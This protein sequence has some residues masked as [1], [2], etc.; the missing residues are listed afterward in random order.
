M[1]EAAAPLEKVHSR[2]ITEDGVMDDATFE[3]VTKLLNR[4]NMLRLQE[5]MKTVLKIAQN[6]MAFAEKIS[7]SPHCTEFMKH[8]DFIMVAL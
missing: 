4:N 6:G 3:G 8:A 7:R 1:E 5:F 2:A